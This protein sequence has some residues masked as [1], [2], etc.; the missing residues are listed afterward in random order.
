MRSVAG[1][2]SWV[3]AWCRL[4]HFGSLSCGVRCGA[5]VPR[6]VHPCGARAGCCV[7]SMRSDTRAC[8]PL[9]CSAKPQHSEVHNDNTIV[10][11]FRSAHSV[12]S[13]PRVSTTP[14]T[15]LRPSAYMAAPKRHSCPST[16]L[17]PDTFLTPLPPG[18]RVQRRRAA[19]RPHPHQAGRDG[20]W[21]CVGAGEGPRQRGLQLCLPAAWPACRYRAA[22]VSSSRLHGVACRHLYCA[23]EYT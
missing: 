1:N 10:V 20:T 13:V 11:L 19:E 14:C 5:R 15:R 3:E 2:V 8:S 23:A 18:P 12:D 4:V 17:P 16:L 7:G 6:R 22:A 9:Y 21:W